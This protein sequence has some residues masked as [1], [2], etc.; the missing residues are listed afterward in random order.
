MYVKL[1]DI[2][3]GNKIF[4]NVCEMGMGDFLS[5][6]QKYLL[7]RLKNIGTEQEKHVLWPAVVMALYW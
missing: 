6:S 4:C 5:L 3:Q 1:D 7:R 2:E